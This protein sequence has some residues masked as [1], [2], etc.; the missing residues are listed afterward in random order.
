M[1]SLSSDNFAHD[2]A[3][4][5]SGIDDEFLGRNKCVFTYLARACLGEIADDVDLL[6]GGEGPDDLANLKNEFL[7]ESR[8][9]VRVIGEFTAT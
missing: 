2:A 7:N 8:L 6:G 4:D 9:V 3:H 1:I 5:L